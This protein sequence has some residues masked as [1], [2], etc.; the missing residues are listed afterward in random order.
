ML[1]VG[2]VLRSER[3]KLG[4]SLEDIAKRTR[5]SKTILQAIENDNLAPVANTFY[6][7]SFAKQF[8]AAVR[9]DFTNLRPA[10]E[11]ATA[12]IPIPLLPG[13]EDRTIRLMPVQKSYGHS[14]R[15][16]VSVFSLVAVLVACSVLYALSNHLGGTHTN[17]VDKP[18]QAQLSKQAHLSQNVVEP[19][20]AT[21]AISAPETILLKIAAVEKTWLSLETDGRNIY[22]GLLEPSDTNVLEGKDSAKI[23]TGNAG[24]LTVTF[25]GKQLGVLGKRGQVQTVLF[26]HDQYEILP[27]G[28]I[29][30]IQLRLAAVPALWAQ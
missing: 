10:L 7:E 23:R 30:H 27:G 12:E 19:D 26:T 25:N 15:W 20:A 24:G 1:S 16:V 29:S 11:S 2:R 9:V 6:Y 14:G 4:F 17:V 22:S 8:A 28:L 5:I 18:L 13:E 21:A 3:E